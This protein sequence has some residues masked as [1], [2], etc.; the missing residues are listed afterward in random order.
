MF[1][2]LLLKEKQYFI[3]SQ[4]FFFENWNKN[5]AKEL[6]QFSLPVEN[7]ENIQKIKQ[8]EENIYKINVAEFFKEYDVDNMVFALIEIKQNTA[9]IFLKTQIQR[10]KLNKNLIIKQFSLNQTQFYER[11]IDTIKNETKEL[12]KS[13][14]LIDVRTPSFLN[15]KININKKD[16][17]VQFNQRSKDI[18]LIDELYVRQLNKDYVLV[19]IKYLGKIDKII[20]KLKD[21]N[22]DLIMTSD[23][24]WEIN[25]I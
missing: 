14:N 3:Y 1:F 2:P 7:I 13:Q 15:V 22:M 11:I 21:Q 9:K 12:I 25:I 23:G 18:D 5:N 6:I 10:K 16:H 20:N 24:Q 17:L 4:N 19:K 8:N